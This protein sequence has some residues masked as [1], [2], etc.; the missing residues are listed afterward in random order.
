MCWVV[1]RSLSWISG[2]YKEYK[3]DNQNYLEIKSAYDEVVEAC[4]AVSGSLKNLVSVALS[5]IFLYFYF[6][7]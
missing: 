3:G 2:L 1:N 6:S 5:V 4:K 7:C